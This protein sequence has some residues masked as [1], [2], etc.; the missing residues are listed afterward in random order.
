MVDTERCIKS[1][2][3]TTTKPT[4]QLT[5]LTTHIVSCL[6]KVARNKVIAEP[7]YPTSKLV[8]YV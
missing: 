7:T 2:W 4:K 5:K 6:R 8:V 3:E 1:E